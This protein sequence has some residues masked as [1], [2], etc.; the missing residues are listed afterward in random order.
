[1]PDGNN[2][3]AKGKEIP[4][5]I[6]GPLMQLLNPM[7]KGGYKTLYDGIYDDEGKVNLYPHQEAG[8]QMPV[9]EDPSAYREFPS[10]EYDYMTDPKNKNFVAYMM[11]GIIND[12]FAGNAHGKH[13]PGKR[14]TNKWG[15]IQDIDPDTIMV[16]DEAQSPVATLMHELMHSDMP[17]TGSISHVSKD[18]RMTDDRDQ[19]KFASIINALFKEKKNSGSIRDM[20]ELEMLSQYNEELINFAK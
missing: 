10:E 6:L 5:E 13:K 18:R 12:S 8:T 4:M 7:T 2:I 20:L 19:A 11:K 14:H 9:I 17:S 16:S 3:A 15:I 1:M